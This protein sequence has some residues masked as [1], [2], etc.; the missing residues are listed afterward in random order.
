MSALSQSLSFITSQNTGTIEVNY[1]NTGTTTMVYTSE[2]VKG[3]GYYGSSDG[4]HTV[5]YTATP[6]F[7]GTV[8]MQ[9]TLAIL[10]V[11][12]DWFNV[13]DTTTTYNKFDIRTTTTV[14]YFNFSGNF[15]WVR[16]SVT[17][18]QGTV[19]SIQYNH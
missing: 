10:P 9:A 2:R 15:V 12:S 14:D 19:D 6:T 1:P 16:G 5:M 8:T 17:I 13:V 18:D 11:E 4:L 7:L 3:N